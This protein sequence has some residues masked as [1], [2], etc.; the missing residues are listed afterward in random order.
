MIDC[1]F[2]VSLDILPKTMF[3]YQAQGMANWKF[4][5]LFLKGKSTTPLA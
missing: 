5:L 1:Q 2:G 3:N 4:F